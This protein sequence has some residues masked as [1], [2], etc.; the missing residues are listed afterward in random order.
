MA[1]V[2][3]LTGSNIGRKVDNLMQ[4]RM[5][6]T[7]KAG[8][9]LRKSSIYESPPWGF[10]H[11]ENFLNQVLEVETFLEP[12]DLLHQLQQIEVELGRKRNRKRYSARII[13]IDILFYADLIIK[14]ESLIIPHPRIDE[15][16]FVLV[17]LNE[18]IPDYHHPLLQQP[19]KELLILCKDKSSVTR[20]E[21]E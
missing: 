13:D 7:Q 10:E 15:R 14:R 8:T 11:P 21:N 17:P 16:R 20:Y 1:V 2:H 12:E 19:V 3:L 9:L 6:I 4:A 18:L 5:F